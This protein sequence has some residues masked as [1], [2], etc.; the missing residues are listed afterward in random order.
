MLDRRGVQRLTGPAALGVRNDFY[1]VED[2]DGAKSSVVEEGVLKR[3]DARAAGL[4]ARILDGDF[5]LEEDD[6]IAFGLWMGLQWLRGAVAR[7]VQQELHDTIQKLVIR[8]GLDVAPRLMEP[9]VPRMRSHAGAPH[10]EIPSL[11]HLPEEV[12]TLLRDQDAYEF[13]LSQ[14]EAVAGMLRGVPE[15]AAPF[16]ERSWMLT[17]LPGRNLLTSDEPISLFREPAPASAP[18]GLGPANA[19]LIQLPLSPNRILIMLPAATAP[20]SV[21]RRPPASAIKGFNALTLHGRW[22]QLYRHPEGDAFPALPP[23]PPERMVTVS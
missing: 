15:A 4:L 3:M 14:E 11:A 8:L 21:A 7:Q 9:D 23:A 13:E 1:T 17:H 19:D 2:A 20:D 22:S 18:M 10:V 6:R 12:Q 5:P 16:L